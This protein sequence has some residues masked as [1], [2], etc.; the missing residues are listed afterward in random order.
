M[1]TL[2]QELLNETELLATNHPSGLSLLECQRLQDTVDVF[3][4]L[5]KQLATFAIPETLHH[6]DLHDGNVF[7]HNGRYIFFDWGD[8]SISHPFFSIRD[9]YANLNRR[10]GLGKNSF[11]FERLKDCYLRSWV[12]YETREKLEVAF[13]IAQKLSPIPDIFRWLP[14]LSNMD[15]AARNNYIDAIPNLLREFLSAIE[16]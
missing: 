11:W 15:K 3:A 9:T 14:V 7:I 2:Y 12:E 16:V 4:S 6:G 10:F 8:S 5:C 1:P 13:E